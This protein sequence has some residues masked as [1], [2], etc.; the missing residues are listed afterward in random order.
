[1]AKDI[2]TN[3]FCGALVLLRAPEPDDLDRF[4]ALDLDSEGARRWGSTHLPVSRAA[5]A[6]WAEEDAARRPTDDKT[7]LAV[8]TLDGVLAGSI[9]VGVADR[10]NGVFSYGIGLGHDHRRRGYGTEA[11]RLLLRFYFAELG[12]QKCDT[13]VYAFNEESLRFHDRLG[14]VVEGRRRRGVFTKGEHH[15]VVLFGLTREEFD[16]HHG[17]LP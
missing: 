6:R 10:R 8:E 3:E 15:D 14:F 1:M 12:Y 17:L 13:T 9:S 4:R 2:V 7:H 11:V 5:Q 16:E